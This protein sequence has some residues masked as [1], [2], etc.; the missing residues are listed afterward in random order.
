MKTVPFYYGHYHDPN[1]LS[2]FELQD[3]SSSQIKTSKKYSS[4]FTTMMNLLNTLIGA[5]ILG[6]ANSMT[7]CG[8]YVSVGLMVICAS[9]SYAATILVIRLQNRTGA[10][11][12]NDLAAK[13]LGRWGGNLLSGLTL[14]FTYS[15]QV[16]YL[17]IG[18]ETVN[19]WLNIAHLYEWE[20]G[21]RR[22]IIVFA[23]SMLL[24]IALTIPKNMGFL[25]TASTAAIG[26]LVVFVIVMIVKACQMLPSQGIEA[27]VESYKFG[28][29]IFNALAI[30]AMIF[31]L[32]AIV[33]P[34]IKP[35]N[36]SLRK[37]YVLIG[38]AFMTCFTIILLP[39]ILGYLMFG[40]GTE[41]II[42]QNFSSSDIIIQIVRVTFFFV[43]NASFPV[44]GIAVATD[45]SDLIYH[46]HDPANLPWGKRIICLL[47]ADAPPLLIAMVLPK[48]RPALEIGG[49]FG[50]CLTN[51]FFPPML[52]LKQSDKKLF[53]PTNILCMLFV[54]FGVISAAIATYQAV[55]DAYHTF[56]GTEE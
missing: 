9:L 47:I 51:F 46:E 42:F 4:C 17:V 38:S 10:E 18:S 31:A 39:S 55:I 37:R 22:A 24:P 23:Y 8:V 13:L 1:I 29:N 32:P 48:V 41:Q 12:I 21:W 36:P 44:V 6:I 3:Q 43:V 14:C 7:L 40:K 54:G 20:S 56:A 35:F 5:E 30:Y 50:G 34:L 53:H 25:D 19:S 33:L 2:S 16:A 28:L 15:C 11:S 52:W 45:I 49:A 26:C 27:S